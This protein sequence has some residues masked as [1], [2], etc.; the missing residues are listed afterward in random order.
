M[1]VLVQWQLYGADE[2]LIGKPYKASNSFYVTVAPT[3]LVLMH[4]LHY[5]VVSFNYGGK[6]KSDIGQTCWSFRAIT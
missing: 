3:I 1:Y 5:C 4:C 2:H 6:E